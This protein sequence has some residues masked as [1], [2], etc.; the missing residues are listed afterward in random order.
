MGRFVY[1][2]ERE[3]D[4]EGERELEEVG[5]RSAHVQ[6]VVCAAV[7]EGRRHTT[8]EMARHPTGAQG[9]LVS[10]GGA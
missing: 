3:R 4:R 1:V 9:Q 10:G 5:V 6:T 2:Y 7:E 8:R